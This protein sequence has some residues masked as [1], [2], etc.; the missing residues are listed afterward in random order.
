MR[1]AVVCVVMLAAAG[2]Y[3]HAYGSTLTLDPIP[4]AVYAGET[5]TFTG[6]LTSGGSPVSGATIR[7]CEDDPF[8]PDECLVRATTG[9]DGRFSVNW[10]A[11]EQ[12]VEIELDIYAKFDG[13]SQYSSDRSSNRYMSVYEAVGQQSAYG[14]TL[15][16]D[17]IPSAVYAGETVTFTGTLTSGGSPVSGATIRI[18]EDDPFIPDECLARGSTSRAGEFAIQWTVKAGWVETEF[19][20]YAKFDGNSQYSSDR[21]SNQYMDVYKR[22][23]SIALDPIPT[24]AALG[25]TIALSGTLALD[26]RSPE[27]SVIYIK[28]EDA[29]NPD[30]LL[31]SAYVDAAG[32]FSTYWVVGDVDPDRTIDIQAVFEGDS[33]YAR[34]ATAIQKITWHGG[35]PEPGPD[36]PGP[37]PPRGEVYMK[38]YRSLDFVQS[39]LVAIVPSPDSYDGVRKHI[40]PVQE[41]ILGL[42]SMLD[43]HSPAG[44]WDVDF[45]VVPPGGSFSVRPDVIVNLVTRDDTSG[46]WNCDDWGG[47]A[48]YQAPKPVPT[49]VCSLDDRTNAQIGATAVHEF[50]HAIGLGHTFNLP[51]DLMCSFEEDYGLTCPGYTGP[52]STVFSELN[53][54]A[55]VAIYGTDG[56]TNPNNQIW[57]D[58]FTPS[59][60]LGSARLDSSGP[61]AEYDVAVMF[62]AW[63]YYHPGE[64]VLLYMLYSGEYDWSAGHATLNP[65]E[66]GVEYEVVY[67]GD[68]VFEIYIDG[69]YTSGVYVFSLYD[70]ESEFVAAAGFEVGYPGNP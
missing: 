58:R 47:W 16:L 3:G 62:P 56:F 27:G 10:V 61:P 60:S 35:P 70:E 40:V 36:P 64:S 18:C 8:I 65:Y 31:T 9:R 29:F 54:D 32:S 17:P 69:I 11:E 66:P 46:Y 26:G 59:G 67:L 68:D 45:E 48:S 53:L 63:N 44:D 28:D 15:T 57:N 19:D 1:A 6:T 37:D 43:R 50:V 13:N 49:T 33:E 42:V 21:S 25:E 34:Q 22:S 7:I 20:I 55:L 4:S 30:D 52:K 38:L 14:S 51:G 24:S 2:A 12:A 41:G 5:V 23:G 39:P